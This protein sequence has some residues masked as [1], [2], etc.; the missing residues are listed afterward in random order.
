MGRQREMSGGLLPL[1]PNMALLPI[2]GFPK[3]NITID[4][5]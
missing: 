1:P 2:T 4:N 3:K 5:W